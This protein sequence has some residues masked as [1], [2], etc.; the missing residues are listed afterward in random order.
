MKKADVLAYFAKLE[1]RK[2]TGVAAAAKALGIKV[3]AVT[4]W[5]EII[6]EAQA[7]KL[8]LLTK[9]KLKYNPEL[10]KAG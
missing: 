1:K 9:G 3:P 5:G 8:H 6:P 10:Y 4:A 2:C 7:T